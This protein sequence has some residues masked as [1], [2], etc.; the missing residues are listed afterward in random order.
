MQKKTNFMQLHFF[1]FFTV[2]SK[3]KISEVPD[4]P[5]ATFL[6][7]SAF[8]TTGDDSF[9]FNFHIM[10]EQEGASSSKSPEDIQTSQN[11][12]NTK[13]EVTSNEK[14][15]EN[16]TKSFKFSSSNTDFKFNFNID[17]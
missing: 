8:L 10:P 1:L 14:T 2:A 6:R 11:N 15:A 9:R 4:K 7:K 12:G 3:I 17:K 5:K 13:N 16:N